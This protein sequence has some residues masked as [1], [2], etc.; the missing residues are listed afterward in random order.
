MLDAVARLPRFTQ[1]ILWVV[2]GFSLAVLPHIPDLRIWI[3]LLACVCAAL[4]IV[5]ALR[6]WALP[7]RLLRTLIALSAMLGVLFTYRTLNGLEAG[8][9]FLAVMGA[10]KLIETRNTRDLTIVIFVAYFLLFAGFLY[11]QSLSRLPWMLLTAWWLTATLMRIH[12]TAPMT[13]RE[14]VRLTGK[15]LLQSLPVMVLL[16]LLFPRLPGQ[17]WAMPARSQATTGLSDEM[18]PGDVSELSVSST[19]AFRVRFDGDA[20][21]PSERYW[22]GPVLHDFDGRTWRRLRNF[23]PPQTLT[24]AGGSYAYTISLEPHNRPWVFALDAVTDWPRDQLLRTFDLQLMARG[25]IATMTTFSLRSSTGYGFGDTLPA[26]TR[27]LDLTAGERNPRAQQFARELRERAGSDEAYLNTVLQ[28]FRDQEFYYTLEPPRL[29]ADSV[30]DFLFNT[31]RG[32]C[33]HFAS[34]FTMLARAAGI[35]AHVV[36]GYQGG[37]LNPLGGYYIVRQSDAHAWSEVW[38]DGQGWVRKDPTAFVAPERIQRGL[39]AAIGEGEPVPDRLLKSSNVLV[40]I[41]F[42]WDAVNTF[43]NDQ[44]I[45][46]GALQQRLMLEHIGIR[47]SDWQVLGVGLALV[48]GAFFAALSLYLAWQFRPRSRD[49]VLQIYTQLSRRLAHRNLAR[50]PHEGPFDYLGRVMR[51][52]PDLAREVEEARSLYISLRY[53]PVPPAAQL[54]ASQLSRLKFLVS[55]LKV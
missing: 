51:A 19:I 50:D 27:V 46:F 55:R 38:L 21:P 25:Q 13:V 7:H 4:R 39:D 5:I 33:E 42:A 40:Q 37:E 53:G 24:P 36:T 28:Y 41:R 34:A 16:F 48:L 18:S 9:A 54:T 8:T 3:P 17:F 52:R 31:R 12:Q 26:S 23:L 45:G 47:D 44:V 6:G 14:A 15:M 32:F 11:H 20:P 29:A 30:D 1:Q 2:G 49:P 35:P 22:R 10:M 43:W